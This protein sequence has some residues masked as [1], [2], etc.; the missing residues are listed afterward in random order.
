M[1][2][3]RR[4][5]VERVST[6]DQLLLRREEISLTM[7]EIYNTMFGISDG[8]VA[9][10]ESINCPSAAPKGFARLASA[11]A[12]VRPRSENHRSLYRVGAQRQNGCA[13]PMRIC[14][15]MARPKMPP[16]ALVPA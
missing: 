12:L 5:T 7:T 14:P 3:M 8:F 11:V 13:R 15:N 9:H 2:S 1:G 10:A 4:L 6:D 16:L